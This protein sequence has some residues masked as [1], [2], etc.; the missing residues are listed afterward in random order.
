MTSLEK[1]RAME[2]LI[3][4][5]EKRDQ[6]IKARTC[7]NGSTQ[8]AYI[9]REEATSPTAATDAILIT[10]V[11]DAKQGR[12]VMTLDVPN[13]FVQTPIPHSGEKVIMKIRGSLVDILLE[14]CPGVYDNYVVYEGRGKQ[15][16]LYVQMLMALYGMM[17]ASIL[18]YKKFRKDIEGVGFEVNPYDICVANR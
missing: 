5:A 7:A 6:T 11:I 9:A 2:S 10:G 12:D 14:I 8:H 1:K 16:V 4:L 17:I 18:Y 15:K 13:A 3:F